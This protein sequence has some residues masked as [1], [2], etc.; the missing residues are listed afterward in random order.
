MSAAT[1]PPTPEPDGQAS[2]AD[3]LARLEVEAALC[4][5]KAA[6]VRCVDTKAWDE[7][8]TLVTEDVEASYAGGAHEASGREALLGFLRDS[9]GSEDILTFHCVSSPELEVTS[10]TT[11]RGNWAILDE[12]LLE[13]LGLR[14]R[15][16]GHYEDE[17][18]FV[19]GSWRISRTAYRR[20][21]EEL[22]PLDPDGTRRL[23]ASLWATAGRSMLA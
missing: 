15:G 6:Y 9:L 8:S 11:A 13:S 20:T 21:F 10:R 4:R 7:M 16:A 18:R 23:T 3:R 17:Y 14:V 1:D 12:V 5:L 2:S 22:V 19:D